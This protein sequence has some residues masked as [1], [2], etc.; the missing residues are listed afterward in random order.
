MSNG[1]ELEEW[2]RTMSNYQMCRHR[3]RWH[4]LTVPVWIH[5]AAVALFYI[6]NGAINSI[7]PCICPP[8]PN[9]AQSANSHSH[10]PSA[11]HQF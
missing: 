8:D 9:S 1:A 2:M 5:T 11:K 3:M 10:L 6:E 7:T 4:R